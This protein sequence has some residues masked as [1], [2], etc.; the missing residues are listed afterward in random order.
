MIALYD[1]ISPDHLA[2]WELFD[3]AYLLLQHMC[4]IQFFVLGGYVLQSVC[5][6][7][8]WVDLL[9]IANHILGGFVMHS[10]CDHDN[11]VDLLC[12]ANHILGGFVMHS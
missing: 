6:H 11:W 4:V 8:N 10:V 1:I 12:M 5:D 2:C 7:D 9:C 3:S